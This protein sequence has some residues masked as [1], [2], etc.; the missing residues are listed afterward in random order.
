MIE[1][2]VVALLA[3]TGM[4][5]LMAALAVKLLFWRINVLLENAQVVPLGLLQMDVRLENT[6]K[7][8]APPINIYNGPPHQGIKL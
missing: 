8:P 6:G 5:V 3:V 2:I 1:L 7:L 4:S